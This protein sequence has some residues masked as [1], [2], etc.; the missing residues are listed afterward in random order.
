MSKLSD[1]TEKFLLH[2]SNFFRIQFLS[3]HS[4]QYTQQMLGTTIYLNDIAK[5]VCTYEHIWHISLGLCN[6]YKAGKQY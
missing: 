6:N 1:K 3:R 2:Y 4:V 5:N